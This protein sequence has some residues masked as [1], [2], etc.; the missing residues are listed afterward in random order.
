MALNIWLLVAVAVVGLMVAVAVALVAIAQ[1]V[2]L[3]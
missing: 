2:D 1:Q 3:Y